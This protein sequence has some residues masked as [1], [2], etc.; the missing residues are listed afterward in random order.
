[1]ALVTVSFSHLGI[2]GVVF[3][4]IKYSISCAIDSLVLPLSW[5]VYSLSLFAYLGFLYCNDIRFS[6]VV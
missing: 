2:R 6:A 3:I 4:D 1:M 5:A